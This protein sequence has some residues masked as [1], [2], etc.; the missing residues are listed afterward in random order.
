MAAGGRNQQRL[1]FAPD[2]MHRDAGGL[3]AKPGG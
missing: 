3:G 1:P 2:A